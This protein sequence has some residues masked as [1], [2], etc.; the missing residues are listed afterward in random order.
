MRAHIRLPGQLTL[1]LALALALACGGSPAPAPVTP[2]P[3]T[4][5]PDVAPPPPTAPAEPPLPLWSQVTRGVLPNGITYYVM[6]HQEPRNRASLWLAVDAGS[7]QEDDDQQGLA[8]FVEHMAFNGTARYPKQAII[9]YLEK[10]GMEFGPDVNAYTSFDETVYQLQVPTDDPSFV[11]TGLDVLREWAGGI[12][13]DPVEVDKERGV[14]LEEWRLGQGPF[15]R[16]FDKQS[17]ILFGGTRYARRLPIGKPDVLKTAPRDALVRYYEDWYRPELMA[18]IVVGDVD[19]RQAVADIAARFGD[20]RGPTRPRPRITAEPLAARGTQVSIETDR[21]LPRTSVAIHNLFP[22]RPE[23]TRGSFREKMIDALYHEMLNERLGQLRRRPGAPFAFASS[24]TGDLTRQFESFSRSAFA[25]DGQA[26]ATFEALMAEVVRVERHGFL[27]G[28]LERARKQLLRRAQQSAAEG[29]K[30]EAY[31]YADEITRNFFEGELMIGRPAEAALW[32]ELLPGIDLAEVNRAARTWGGADSRVILI[33]GPTGAALPTRERV[34]ELTREIEARAL[35]PWQDATPTAPLLAQAP[36][37]GAITGEKVIAPLGVT[38]WTL[39]N[40]VRVVLKPTDFE[41]QRVYL[42]ASGPGGLSQHPDADYLSGRNATAIVSAGGAGPHSADDLDKLLAGRTAQAGAWI[43]DYEEGAWGQAASDE[44]EV[45]FQLVHL[46]LTAPRRDEAAF[47]AWKEAQVA[48]LKNRTLLP[49]TVFRDELQRVLTRDHLRRRPPALADL[50]R[51]DLDRAHAIFRARFADVSDLTFHLV[52][53]FDPAAVRP[54]VETYLASLPGGGRKETRK[55]QGIRNPRGVIARE[56]RAGTAPK[57]QV[58]ITFH[59]DARWSRDAAIDLDVLAEVLRMRLREI[60]REDMGGVY[61]VGVWGAFT[62]APRQVHTL[63]I[64][65]GCAPENVAALR[66]AVFDEVRR[67][68]RGGVDSSYV[69]KV[70]EQRRRAFEVDARR[71]YWWQRQLDEAYDFGDDPRR[72]V[73]LDAV[74]ARVTSDRIRKAAG[75]FA[76]S[77]K[78]VSGV[79]LPAGEPAAADPGAGESPA[80]PPPPPPTGTPAPAPTPE[81]A[82]GL[83]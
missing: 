80:P 71:N 36:A 83:P 26:E 72:I 27:P 39:S 42:S 60:L 37:A 12:A 54:L 23:A 15:R 4:A 22:H 34:L 61:G 1:A 24:S 64:N 52:G 69:A 19:P 21:E 41:N 7:L 59:D 44:L 9:D 77:R 32:A 81:P 79:L 31:S 78:Y 70:K 46:R 63:T 76:S 74:L 30:E 18:V 8:H 20:L 2:A 75:R 58:S 13:F 33:S 16:V 62:R 14:V 35:E 55:D 28:E 17:A 3:V 10:I 68:Q 51:V 50:E 49:E 38:E 48:F 11:T 73:D 6:P 57:A 5:G 40:G 47:T 53:S 67:M 43:D 56:V 66:Q 45:L 82:P 25:K 65:F 29:D